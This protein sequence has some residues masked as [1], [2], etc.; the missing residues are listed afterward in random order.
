MHVPWHLLASS[1]CSRGPSSGPLLWHHGQP[2]RGVT[3]SPRPLCSL[4][5]NPTPG[6]AIE[7]QAAH[8][9]CSVDIQ[10]KMICLYFIMKQNS[11]EEC[12]ICL[13]ERETTAF[14]SRLLGVLNFAVSKV[15]LKRSSSNYTAGN[16]VSCNFGLK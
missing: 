10:L 2:Y 7:A 15:F 11:A 14:L 9:L 6:I 13:L 12:F 1:C 16:S 4:Q 5:Q 8:I 3:E